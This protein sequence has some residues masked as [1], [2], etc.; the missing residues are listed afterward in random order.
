[1]SDAR[2]Q[3]KTLMGQGATTQESRPALALEVTGLWAGYNSTPVLEDVSFSVTGAGI[4]GI[5]GPNGSGKSTLLKV[6]LGLLKPWHGDVRIGGQPAAAWRRRI[7]YMPQSDRVDWDF[8]VTVFDVVMMGR[9]SRLGPLRRPG[10]QDKEAVWRALEAVGLEAFA[11]RGIGELSGGQ[12]RR[13]LIARALA[14][15][16]D[17]LLLDEPTANLDAGSQH[18]L[19]ALFG[20]LREEGRTLLVATHDLSCVLTDF[21]YALCLNHRVIAFGP[22]RAVFTPEILNTTFAHHLLQLSIA[23]DI[24]VGHALPDGPA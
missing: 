5:V 24:Y 4:V 9:Y 14:Q 17:L 3:D 22:P 18:D 2:H 23:G 1:M 6:I 16:A 21:D 20:K 15:E 13:V 12:Q 19:L 8:P 10:K 7:G 11:D